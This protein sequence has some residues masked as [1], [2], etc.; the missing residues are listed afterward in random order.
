[1]EIGD[2]TS[3]RQLWLRGGIPDSFLSPNDQLSLQWRK[4]FIRTYLERDLPRL[5]LGADLVQMRRFWQML[6]SQHGML[7]HGEKFA[8]SLGVSGHTVKRYLNFLESAFLVTALQPWF[9]N[10]GKRLVKSPKIFLR[11]SGLLHAWL[12]IATLDDLLG[13]VIL[14]TSWE[15]FVI[16]QIK[17][18]AGDKL[19]Y[20]FYRT[21]QGAECDLVLVKGGNPVAA[22]EIKFSSTP[23]ISKGFYISISDLKTSTNFVIIPD[24]SGEDDYLLKEGIRVVGIYLFLKKYLPALV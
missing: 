2:P 3:W 16:E 19:Q 4:N 23:S 9:T 8:T 7:W 24:I 1:L 15:G 13:N 21:H 17:A 14:G 18:M 12:E 5:G 22:I 20:H 10:V 11:D 6:A